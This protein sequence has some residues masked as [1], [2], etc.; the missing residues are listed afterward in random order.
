MYDQSDV[1]LAECKQMLIGEGWTLQY[2]KGDTEFWCRPGKAEGI[3]A[4]FKGN[5]FYVFSSNANPFDNEKYYFPSQIYTYI[6]YGTQSDDF[7]K[8]TLDF[9]NKGFGKRISMNRGGS[10]IEIADVEEFL[11]E[12]YDFRLNEVTSMLEWKKK[13]EENFRAAEDYDLSSIHRSLQHRGIKYGYDKLNNL[14]NSDFINRYDPL[15][16]YFE[17]LPQWDGVDYIK[18]LSSTVKLRNPSLN[19]YWYMGLRKFLIAMVGCATVPEI[20]NETSIIFYGAQGEGKTKWLNRLVPEELNPQQYLFVGTIYDDKDSKINFS[21]RLLINLDELGSFNRQEIGYLKS[22]FTLNT[23]SLREPYMRK[24]KN[25]IRRASFVG[26]IDRE[27][28]LTDLSGTRRFLTYA[29]AEVDYQHTVDIEK[30]FSQAYSLFK[31]GERYYFNRDEIKEINDHN[32]EF[33]LKSFEEELLQLNFSIPEYASSASSMTTTEIANVLSNSNLSF[34]VTNAS[35]KK[36]GEAMNKLG[37]EKKS[38]KKDGKPLKCWLVK[39]V[40]PLARMSNIS[41]VQGIMQN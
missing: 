36:I 18:E 4:S 29:V 12:E 32:E 22:L 7:K 28:F 37:Y 34:K 6:K 25:F 27:E 19:D 21:T 15:R 30:V 40:S 2:E 17:S 9:L 20:T 24:N 5:T 39:R 35:L 8:S 10:N 14:L 41:A 23:I 38:I 13:N 3:S 11:S 16:E 33:R 26:S 1:G 31:Q